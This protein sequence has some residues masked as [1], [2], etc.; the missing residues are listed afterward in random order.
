M[1]KAKVPGP[2]VPPG[3]EQAH[4]P[5]RFQIEGGKVTTLEVIAQMAR[6]RQIFFIRPAAVLGS[7]YVVRLMRKPHVFLVN[8]VILAAI[9]GAAP[10][11]GPETG[12]NVLTHRDRPEEWTMALT[13]RI[14]RSACA[15]SLN[16]CSS[17]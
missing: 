7:N 4:N 15:N 14:R 2:S 16:S 11:I 8:E 10:N 17:S 9:P 6:P 5:A 3:V 1:F 13:N 12:R